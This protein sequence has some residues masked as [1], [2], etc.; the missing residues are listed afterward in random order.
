MI[1]VK[2][3]L[4]IFLTIFSFQAVAG[5]AKLYVAT[6]KD[7]YAS[8]ESVQFQVFLLNERNSN[9]TV[10]VELWDCG[11][12][13][14]A[15]KMLPL[16]SSTSWGHIE[17][18]QPANAQFYLLYCYIISKEAVEIDCSKKIF[19]SDHYS[20]LPDDAEQNMLVEYFPEGGTFVAELDNNLLIKCADQN[21]NPV[22]A[23]GK[24]VD[25]K[26]RLLTAFNTDESGLA[27]IRFN[28]QAKTRYF[29]IIE[30]R[31]GKITRKEI[32]PASEYGV[33]I[34]IMN[35]KDSITYKVFSYTADENQLEYKMDILSDGEVVYTSDIS[36]QL[37]LSFIQ[38][39]LKAADLPEGF[40][41]F[42]LTDKNNKLHAQRIIYNEHPKPEEILL[43]I[44]DTL[45]NRMAT[46]VVPGY[47]NSKACLN[48]LSNDAGLN[49]LKRERIDRSAQVVIKQ[50][51]GDRISINDLLLSE[52]KAP[53]KLTGA[54]V[55]SNPFLTLSG[56]VYTADHKPVKKKKVNLIFLHKDHKKDY[57][58][59]TTDRDGSFELSSL[60]FYDTVTVYYQLADEEEGKN[61][62]F[63]DI[64]VTPA[65]YFTGNESRE[66]NFQCAVKPLNAGASATPVN[67]INN[68]SNS[69]PSNNEKTL[70]EVIVKGRK[71]KPKTNTEKYVEQ[72]VSPVNNQA[73]FMRNEIDLIANPQVI[74]NTPLFNFLRGR[75]SSLLIKISPRGDVI[76]TTVSG[77]GIGVYLDDMEVTEDLTMV[78]NLRVSDVALVRYYSMPLKPRLSSTKTKYS[79][80]FSS[81]GGGGGGDLMIYTKKGFTPT[82]ALVKGLPKTTISGYDPDGPVVSPPGSAGIQQSLYWKPNWAQKKEVTIYTALPAGSADKKIQLIIEGVNSSDNPFSVTKNLVFN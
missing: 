32:T 49:T 47:V 42:R 10:Y 12:N 36:F 29:I 23:K 44:I 30:N 19:I 79:G 72:Y 37:S 34:S 56:I 15:K 14:V 68:S 46:A 24:I 81:G 38:E 20:L 11:G 43:R 78:A 51:P 52:Q 58:V 2:N 80:F 9:K 4:T 7:I 55:N 62:V 66:I 48:I 61:D 60:I 67:N 50:V 39:T 16:M 17:L 25:E 57:Q 54:E 65:G 8:A 70:S 45:S 21:E 69:N 76:V 3:W 27:M 22:A 41:V 28:P 33:N 64:K 1:K 18:P 13:R 73:S 59:V 53:G 6:N 82:E 77:E 31:N 26:N 75:M 35:Q 63:I 74:D 40:L 5:N 71:E